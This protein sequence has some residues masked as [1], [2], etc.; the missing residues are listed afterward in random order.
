MGDTLQEYARQIE[1]AYRR[2]RDLRISLTSQIGTVSKK[3]FDD[4]NRQITQYNKQVDQFASKFPSAPQS[5]P[6][7]NLVT[8][9]ELK[10]TLEG[11][12]EGTGEGKYTVWVYFRVDGLWVKQPKMTLNTDDPKVAND[13]VAKAKALGDDCTATTNAPVSQERALVGPFY[14]HTG[15]YSNDQYR[16]IGSVGP[17]VRTIDGGGNRGQE[18]ETFAEAHAAAQEFMN[19]GGQR[20]YRI[21]DKNTKTLESGR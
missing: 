15:A 8:Q 17:S 7:L 10:G 5:S 18:F 12:R 14:L 2:V 9:S 11:S 13:C 4:V 21:E 3:K 6:R 1:D 16:P 19:G 20:S